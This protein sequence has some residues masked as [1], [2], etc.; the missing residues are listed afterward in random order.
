MEQ[1]SKSEPF[2]YDVARLDGSEEGTRFEARTPY[3]QIIY[4]GKTEKEAIGWMLADMV[5]LGRDGSIHPDYPHRPGVP[6]IQHALSL[7]TEQLAF[8]I[9][10]R[11]QGFS[12]AAATLGQ[13]KNGG[14]S[15][16]D[17]TYQQVADASPMFQRRNE[18]IAGLA[19]AIA[20]LAR[21]KE[22]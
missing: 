20:A 14:L 12:D 9:D 22:L 1:Q 17:M 8:E 7:L 19:T 18:V 10:T 13:T 4:E 15:P 5:R 11:R 3:R 2:E 6:P 21:V 16:S